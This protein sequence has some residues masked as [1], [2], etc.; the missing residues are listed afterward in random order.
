ME[1]QHN[2]PGMN[3]NRL[4]E[5]NRSSLAK[6]LEKLASGYAVNRAGDDAA[7]LGVSE[8][9]RSQIHGMKQSV[10]N[11]SDGISLIQ[12]FEGALDQ[13]VTIIKRMKSL[14]V[15]SA[16]GSYCDT[17]DRTAIDVEFRQLGDEINHIADTDFNGIV[18]LNDRCMSDT[19]SFLTDD[20]VKQVAPETLEW[21]SYENSTNVPGLKMN[22]KKLPG[23]AA[24]S[25]YD[26]YIFES[27]AMLENSTVSADLKKGFPEYYFTD[28]VPANFSIRT[29]D[30]VG[31]ITYHAPN[32][33]SAD[34]AEVSLPEIPHNAYSKASGIWV[35]GGIGS[36]SITVP[37]GCGDFSTEE[38]RRKYHD[39]LCTVPTVTVTVNDDIK[40]YTDPSGNIYDKDKNI[41]PIKSTPPTTATI[42][43]SE[44]SV[45]PGD[46]ITVGQSH[47]NSIYPSDSLGQ[48]VE[49][50]PPSDDDPDGKREWRTQSFSIGSIS[51]SKAEEY[52]IKHGSFSCTFRYSTAT[53]SWQGDSPNKYTSELGI[54]DSTIASSL[55]A[56]R[57]KGITKDDVL[58]FS[59]YIG[60]CGTGT[61]NGGYRWSNNTVNNDFSMGEYDPSQP[62][63]GGIDYR[64]AEDGAVY[65][66]VN[67]SHVST[68]AEGH[69]EDAEG[70]P[71]NLESVG[72]Y[73][74]SK[75]EDG[76]RL[77]DTDI[78]HHGMQIRV[79]NPLDGATGTVSG[80]LHFW[81]SQTDAF[82]VGYENL[83]FA[84]DLII[85]AG[86]R[87]KDL[88]EFTFNYSAGGIGELEA[89]LNCTTAGL[90]LDGLDVTTQ[91]G[92]NLAIDRLDTA[93]AK[94]S[95]VRSS[96]GAAQNR[97]EHKIDNL[98][99]TVENLTQAESR[100]RDTDM[101]KEMAEFTKSQILGQTSEALLA[102]ANALPQQMAGLLDLQQ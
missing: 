40:T 41:L 90:G 64:I 62:E 87:T 59:V 57:G 16:N 67:D 28:E 80:T 73:L 49:T 29:E 10:R 13:T 83:T 9:M 31:I 93:L 99:N 20:G 74:P 50:V 78:L 1:L 24:V 11:C 44:P 91:A 47:I 43:W 45:K 52:W 15:Q 94:V 32:G 96:F 68:A 95:M 37:A 19:F 69:W 39:W 26:K 42:T 18:M 25:D 36:G 86:G 58:T 89:D 3:T 14:A 38:G 102:Q 17:V 23:F 97:L 53:G 71:V 12:T 88:V 54:S 2:L 46:T 55:A 22:I 56:A 65:T 5:K 84:E 34:V 101:A 92:A 61:Y 48:Y 82:R 63:K 76:S 35:Y 6:S 66:Y 75:P 81:D 4:Y 77:P 33:Q 70:R 27:I 8:K 100:I 72:V 21:H 60:P 30:F 98:N 79:T 7:G 51:S 85:Q